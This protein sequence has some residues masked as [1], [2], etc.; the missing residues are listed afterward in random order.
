MAQ[1][2]REREREKER[3]RDPAKAEL[4]YIS[5]QGTASTTGYIGARLCD[6]LCRLA[7][8]RLTCDGEIISVL[9]GA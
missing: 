8:G 7:D 5:T 2:G 9:Q 4:D 1:E 6:V 3:E